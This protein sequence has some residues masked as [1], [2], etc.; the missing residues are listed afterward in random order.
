MNRLLRFLG[1]VLALILLTFCV[2]FV[3]ARLLPE[4]LLRPFF[5][6]R[7]STVVGEF[8]VTATDTAS[9]IKGTATVHGNPGAL[10]KIAVAPSEATLLSGSTLVVAATGYDAKALDYAALQ[11]AFEQAVASGELRQGEQQRDQA[12]L[13]RGDV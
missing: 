12:R 1:L 9:G 7:F 5:T 13:A 6:A 10:A 3:S 11:D 2:W 4:G 8:T